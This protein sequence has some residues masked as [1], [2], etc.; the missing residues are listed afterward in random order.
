M[1]VRRPPIEKWA[2]VPSWLKPKS[3]WDIFRGGP[4][5]TGDSSPRSSPPVRFL[6]FRKSAAAMPK[7]WQMA[8]LVELVISFICVGSCPNRMCRGNTRSRQ[9]RQPGQ[10]QVP[11]CPCRRA[12]PP[13]MAIEFEPEAGSPLAESASETDLGGAGDRNSEQRFGERREAWPARDRWQA[14]GL[15]EAT[16]RSAAPAGSHGGLGPRTAEGGTGAGLPGPQG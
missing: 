13:P 8:F 6:P 10:P 9:P 1:G 2:K 3:P 14:G 12:G 7:G 5:L 15:F 4:S 16:L 11:G